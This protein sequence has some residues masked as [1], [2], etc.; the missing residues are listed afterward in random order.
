MAISAWGMILT[1]CHHGCCRAAASMVCV[2]PQLPEDV[3]RMLGI[4]PLQDIVSETVDAGQ[5]LVYLDALEVTC[6]SI[7]CQLT[8]TAV[9]QSLACA[10]SS[11]D[12]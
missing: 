6:G 2:H 11:V 9:V 7:L 3:C 12:L 5:P 4:P 8:G 10:G 1:V